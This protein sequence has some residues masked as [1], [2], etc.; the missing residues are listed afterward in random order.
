MNSQTPK[1]NILFI[2]T[3]EQFGGA[4]VTLAQ[5]VRNVD[6]NVYHP[7]VILSCRNSRSIDLGKFTDVAII[8]FNSISN[9]SA[10]GIIITRIFGWMNMK[11]DS[12]LITLI[13]F[14]FYTLPYTFRLY[15]YAKRRNI[16][17][18]HLNNG[19]LS[20]R[21]GILLA[22]LLNRPCVCHQRGFE[23]KSPVTKWY[24]KL[25]DLN[26]ADSEAVKQ[27]LIESGAI[28][29]RI[30]VIYDAI[31]LES[32]FSKL[33]CEGI[34]KKY[35]LN[36]NES[37]IGIAAR[38]VKGKGHGDFI[39]AATT[40]V[41]SFPKSQFLVIGSNNS[42]EGTV[43]IKNLKNQVEALGLNKSVI[44]TGWVD[45]I[46]EITS[47]LDVAVQ[48]SHL[49]EGLGTA[50]IEAMAM[51][52][53]VVATAVGGVVELVED[54]ITGFLVPP[55]NSPALSGAILKLLN[56]EE[57]AKFMGRLGRERAEEKF[58]IK[59]HILLIEK[60]YTNLLQCD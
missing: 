2:D 49:P 5:L 59:K 19:V 60:I 25:I 44:F 12:A 13:D 8:K 17:L 26:I 10:I 24:S 53:P 9:S 48:A 23:W 37:I 33:D 16:D 27:N 47:I 45:N 21:G 11:I 14:I 1:F 55:G 54:G 22:K 43:F 39:T 7:Y 30:R 3:T 29:S 38:L 18:I 31:D 35:N 56:N 51:G 28:S 46:F 15:L 40:I 20:N 36:P 58:N 57:R 52:K 50:I 32:Y 4:I 6:T 41:Q 42:T 34:K